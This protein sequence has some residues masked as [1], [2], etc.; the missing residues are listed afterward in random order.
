MI[1][2][3]LRLPVE[4]TLLLSSFFRSGSAGDERQQMPQTAGILPEKVDRA[5][6]RAVVPPEKFQIRV[7]GRRP[8]KLPAQ[9]RALQGN[10]PR[11]HLRH[12]GFPILDFLGEQR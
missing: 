8:A 7:A 4:E 6:R 12:G 9:L 5:V 11:R 3:R 1:S 10:H 2:N